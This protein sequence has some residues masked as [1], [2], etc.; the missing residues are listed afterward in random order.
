MRKERR[1][2]IE[3]KNLEKTYKGKKTE[4]KAVDDVSFSVY[5]NEILGLLGPNGSGKTTTINVILGFLKYEK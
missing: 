3:V 2:V 1:K 5:E 4:V